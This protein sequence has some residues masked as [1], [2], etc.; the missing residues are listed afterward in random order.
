MPLQLEHLIGQ[1]LLWSFNGRIPPADFL[2]ALSKGHVGGVTLFRS[3][4]L[5]NPS[6]IRE[7]TTALQ[8]AAREARQPPL[9]IG[10]DQEGGTLMAVPGTSRFPGNL[11][12]GAAYRRLK[13]RKGA[14]IAITAL[15]NGERPR[16]RS[17]GARQGGRIGIGRH[18]PRPRGHRP[19]TAHPGVDAGAKLTTDNG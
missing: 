6:Q 7:L 5:D 18:E 16:R 11:A 10:A 9:L 17:A 14:P 12:L 3:L 4:N 19:H 2:T 13:A 1:K 8:Y 15:A